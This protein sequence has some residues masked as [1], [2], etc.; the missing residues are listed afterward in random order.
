MELK[1][2]LFAPVPNIAWPVAGELKTRDDI[3][4][5]ALAKAP[6]PISAGLEIIVTSG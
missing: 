2:P 5:D 6:E 1:V 3:L 4:S